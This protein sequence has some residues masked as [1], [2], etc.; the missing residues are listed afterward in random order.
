M[1]Q[2]EKSR[3][4]RQARCLRFEQTYSESLAQRRMHKDI[5]TTEKTTQIVTETTETDICLKPGSCNLL[6]EF[7]LQR[8]LPEQQQTRCRKT[9]GNLAPFVQ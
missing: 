5:G 2:P 8:T 6:P 9:A 1:G 7:I 3:N 4:H